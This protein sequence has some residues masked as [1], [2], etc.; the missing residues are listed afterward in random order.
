MYYLLQVYYNHNCFTYVACWL[1]EKKIREVI[2]FAV[3]MVVVIC[4][5]MQFKYSWS[6]K[7]CPK[8]GLFK[9]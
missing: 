9:S 7:I 2:L 8:V 5:Y 1:G 6:S 3:L 4:R